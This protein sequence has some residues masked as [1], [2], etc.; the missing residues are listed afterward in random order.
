MMESARNTA[1]ASLL[2]R[3]VVAITF[4]RAAAAEMSERVAEGLLRLSNGDL[5]IVG[6]YP[7][8]LLNTFLELFK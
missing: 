8:L 6:M 1:I 4:L 7:Q 2:V 3:R 5:S